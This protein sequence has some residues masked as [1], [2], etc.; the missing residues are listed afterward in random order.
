MP[1]AHSKFASNFEKKDRKRHWLA[2]PGP[3]RGS[4]SK[5]PLLNSGVQTSINQNQRSNKSQ[6]DTQENVDISDF[7]SQSVRTSSE[8]LQNTFTRV[9]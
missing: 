9:G 7:Q 8:K 2:T 4:M 5:Y 3:L 6:T 1:R